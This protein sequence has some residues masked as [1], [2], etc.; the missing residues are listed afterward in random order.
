MSTLPERNAP[1]VLV[2]DDDRLILATLAASLTHAGYAVSTATSA[3]EAESYLAGGR[4]PDL[5]I[6]DVRMPGHSGLHLAQRL[7]NLDHIPFIMLSAYSDEKTVQEAVAH[8]ALSFLVKP[9]DDAQLLPAI[10]AALARAQELDD[11][12]STRQQLQH[13]LDGDRV[14]NLAVGIT[15]AQHHLSRQQAFE[16]LRRAARS[17]NTRLSE[18]AQALVSSLETA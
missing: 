4:R 5:V 3:E 8:G 12:R 9:L 18:L 15:M 7:R 1:Q 6:L 17:K 14:I 13:A 11:L 10:E 2:V 16:Q